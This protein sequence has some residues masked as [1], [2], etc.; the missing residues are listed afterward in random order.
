[1]PP[2]TLPAPAPAGASEGPEAQIGR[3]LA[4]HV[5]TA[6]RVVPR[7]ADAV[8]EE[9]IVLEFPVTS[10]T[11]VER[12]FGYEVLSHRKSDVDLSRAQRGVAILLSDQAWM[13]HY[14]TRIGITLDAWVEEKENRTWVRAKFARDQFSQDAVRKIQDGV[15]V[16]VSA[17]YI[18]G[19]IKLLEERK[20]GP[21]TYLVAPWTLCEVTFVN[22]V[23]ADPT[24][25]FGRALDA[26]HPYPLPIPGRSATPQEETTMPPDAPGATTRT[27]EPPATAP[28]PAPAGPATRSL[29]P[30][31]INQIMEMCDFEHVSQ[32]RRAQFIEQ[33]MAPSEVAYALFTER[34][35][36]L[37]ALQPAAETGL[38][39]SDEMRSHS[40]RRA[41]ELLVR[42]RQTG[43][44]FDGAE[45]T[46]HKAMRASAPEGY[47]DRSGIIVPLLLGRGRGYSV[48]SAGAQVGTGIANAGAELVETYRQETIDIIRPRAVLQMLGA[49]VLPD[50]TGQL[51]WPKVSADP[52]V[53]WMKENPA[54]GAA[55]TKTAY[56][57]ITSNPKTLIGNYPIPRQ[58]LRATSFDAEADVERRFLVGTNQ[59]IDRGGWHG[60]GT[61]NEPAGM[62]SLADVQ[63]VTM[64]GVPTNTK[65]QRMIGKVPDGTPGALAFA[66]TRLMAS[67]LAATLKVTNGQR[68]VWEGP[69]EDGLM[70][71]YRSTS[72]DQISRLLGTGA[73]HG[74]IFGPFDTIVIP[75]W[76]AVEI[77]IDET[78]YADEGAIR[79]ISF[80]MA[81]V[82]CE[83]P[84][85]F[86]KA[87]TAV[88]SAE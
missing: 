57:W 41:I 5:R 69:L 18:P 71:G 39:A 75:M 27:A 52:V 2:E 10:E 76:G 72:T 50:V 11:P 55:A 29:E 13:D 58:L 15:L 26:R 32:E 74:L 6:V 63:T 49:R 83:Y 65:I 40:V 79:V 44:A 28:A 87:L 30:R 3:Q 62:F 47:V 1:M 19:D 34:R 66:T 8:G 81:D 14:G 17:G 33:R 80:G 9:F 16:D 85:A 46:I 37:G 38:A 70:C 56:K 67:E 59:A 25:G 84:E 23:P 31:E 21:S 86:V 82:I 42:R 73:D 45:G 77:V 64:G 20:D 78:T 54:T 51:I 12:Y 68:F 60:K 88:I 36:G 48:R 43:Q 61:S 53:R 7:A 24:V 22:G 35:T 4:M